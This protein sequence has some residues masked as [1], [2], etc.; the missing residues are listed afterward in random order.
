VSPR[1][2][3][4]KCFDRKQ[5]RR[6]NRSS[7]ISAP[8]SKPH[9]GR[10]LRSR[11]SIK[12]ECDATDPSE[13]C[14]LDPAF[15]QHQIRNHE[16]RLSAPLCQTAVPSLALKEQSRR[17]AQIQREKID[18]VLLV[19]DDEDTLARHASMRARL[20]GQLLRVARDGDF[21]PPFRSAL[22][23]L[24]QAGNDLGPLFKTV[25]ASFSRIRPALR[26]LR[27]RIITASALL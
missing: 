8:N 12:T 3:S 2:Y 7:L 17:F 1:H 4:R 11:V 15:S 9:A 26:H 10:V 25:R 22:R 13:V 24:L 6:L 23:E 14:K 16:I 21:T 5:L 18:N 19:F 20:A 27:Q